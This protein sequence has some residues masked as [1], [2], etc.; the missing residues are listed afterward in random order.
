MFAKISAFCLILDESSVFMDAMNK[1]LIT[2]PL[3]RFFPGLYDKALGWRL[4]ATRSKRPRNLTQKD[5][6]AVARICKGDR[7]ALADYLANR[8]EIS[9]LIDPPLV[10]IIKKLK[11]DCNLRNFVETG[12][13][14]GETSF[15]FSLLFDRVFTCDVV[16]HP[17]RVDFFFRNNLVYETCSSPDFLR[18]HLAE[19]REHSMFYLDAHWMSYWP[20]RDELAIV[21]GECAHPVVIIDDFD[22]E[23]GLGFDCWDGKRLCYEY[24][25]DIVPSTCKFIRNP[26]SNRNR[27]LIIMFPEVLP[28]GCP[29]KDWSNY[30][31]QKHGLW[32]ITGPSPVSIKPFAEEASIKTGLPQM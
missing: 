5:F 29:I 26:W 20:L 18:R 12:T 13:Y 24:I 4:A 11:D 25:K 22:V 17:K 23:N 16:D 27:G 10:N 14:F 8:Y 1:T 31:E 32:E 6:A 21:Y 15:F 2:R 19:I 7:T 3:R 28:Y 9:S 30:S